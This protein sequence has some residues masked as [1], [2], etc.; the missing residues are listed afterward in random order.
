MRASVGD[1]WRDDGLDFSWQTKQ[2]WSA[3]LGVYDG[4]GFPSVKSAGLN[5]INGHIGWQ[6]ERSSF[7]MSMPILMSMAAPPNKAP[8]LGQAES[9][10]LSC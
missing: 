7:S 3:G 4:D 10:T 5:A 9:I 8:Q 2:G 1:G 6:G